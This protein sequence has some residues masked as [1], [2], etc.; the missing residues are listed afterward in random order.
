VPVMSYGEPRSYSK[1]I[2]SGLSASNI[3]HV[4]FV[5]VTR[6]AS[7]VPKVNGSVATSNATPRKALE[8]LDIFMLF[9]SVN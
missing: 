4:A 9:L 5:K 7:A 8:I 3:V 2:T 6:E 1:G